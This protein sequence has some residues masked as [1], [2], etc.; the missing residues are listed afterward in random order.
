MQKITT[1][2]VDVN[3]VQIITSSATHINE[4]QE[5]TVSPPPNTLELQS[6]WSYALQ[7]DTS[8]HGGSLQHSGQISALAP[9][10][11]SRDSLAEIINNM[12]NVDSGVQV[13]KSTQNQDGGYTYSVTF[14][15]SMKNPPQ[16]EIFLSDI[17]VTV[18]TIENGNLIDGTFRLGFEGETSENINFNADAA[19]MQGKLEALSSIGS[20][21]VF[22]GAADDQNGFSW[23]IEFTSDFNGGDLSNI[24]IYDETIMTTNPS[25]QARLELSEG[26]VNGSY[27]TGTFK[28]EYGMY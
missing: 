27:I 19:E 25:G 2:A 13:T 10:S 26:G 8:A 7:L 3:E 28:L 15:L 21:N 22:R 14:P 4:V 6:F 12:I 17:P 1:S 24:N 20:V 11:G 18:Q 9:S 5:I 23:E 16:L